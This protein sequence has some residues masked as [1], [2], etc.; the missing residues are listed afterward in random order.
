MPL[1]NGIQKYFPALGGRELKGGGYNK[2][3]TLLLIS[4]PQGRKTTE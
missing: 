1:K 2:I 3:F 4:S